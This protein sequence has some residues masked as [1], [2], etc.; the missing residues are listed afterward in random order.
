MYQLRASLVSLTRL[1]F[2]QVCQFFSCAFRR[3]ELPVKAVI[4]IVQIG[5]HY[6]VVL[7]FRHVW[8]GMFIEFRYVQRV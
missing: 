3:P 2:T 5:G 6:L 7:R 4:E 1:T 8:L